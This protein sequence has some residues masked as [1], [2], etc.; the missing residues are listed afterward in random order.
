[1]YTKN[2]WK[3]GKWKEYM[4]FVCIFVSPIVMFNSSLWGQCDSIYTFFA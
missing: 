4:T 2:I 3:N 1:M